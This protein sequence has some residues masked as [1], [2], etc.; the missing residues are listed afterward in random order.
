MARSLFAKI[1]LWSV[2]VQLLSVGTILT[3]V[4][5]YLPESQQ[6]VDNAF[7]LYADTAVAL[8][9]RFGPEAVDDF[10]ASSGESTL[11]HLKLSASDTGSGG[12]TGTDCGPHGERETRILAR[13]H[14]GA[15]CLTVRSKTGGGLPSPAEDRRSRMQILLLV[16]LSAC[17]ALSYAI[18]RYLSR[19]ISQLRRIAGR[20]A[21]GDLAARVGPR[22]DSRRDEAADLVR[23]FDLMADRI[24]A[25]VTAQRRLIGDVSHEIKSPLGR[26]SIALELGKREAGDH[27]PRQFDRMRREID[28]IARLVE[29]LLT[30]ARLD[31]A[32][33]SLPDE[34]F[35][36]GDLLA[37]VV[38]DIAFELPDRADDLALDPVDQ[39]V[40]VRGD[41]NLMGRAIGNV[42]RNAV[43]YTMPGARISLSCTTET[44]RSRVVI[45]DQGPG[46]PEPALPR[47]FDP[48]YRT[49]DARNRRTG[50]TGIGLAICR[51]AVLLH[52]GTVTASNLVPHG[53]SVVIELPQVV[54]EI[55]AQQDS[56]QLHNSPV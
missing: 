10:L 33:A 29:E 51:S 9:E 23:E 34:R 20:L 1:L 40:P 46:V 24:G 47:L 42:V 13:G 8:Y 52:G 45:A 2:A 25:L 6:A 28:N 5:Y 55:R 54:A 4:T 11:L 27:A 14:G 36:L 22:F 38:A 37:D 43:F 50:G 26:L 44:G 7:Q 3:L 21:K 15:Y 16:E 56:T 39:P 41:R 17:L 12:G 49:D 31:S 35:D 18:A 53:L 48:F 19:P 32:G 30:L